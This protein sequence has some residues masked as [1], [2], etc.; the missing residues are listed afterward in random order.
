MANKNQDNKIPMDPVNKA[1]YDAAGRFSQQLFLRVMYLDAGILF[2]FSGVFISLALCFVPNLI[3]EVFSVK[4]IYFIFIGGLWIVATYAFYKIGLIVNSVPV[5]PNR[6]KSP[7][8]AWRAFVSNKG[9]LIK[10]LFICGASVI[11]SILVVFFHI[12]CISTTT[13]E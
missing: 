10:A 2:F 7:D 8:A 4:T 1:E 6:E 9:N 3:D 12:L 13:G 11:L 5:E